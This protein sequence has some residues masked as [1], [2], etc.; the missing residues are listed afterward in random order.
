MINDLL[1]LTEANILLLSEDPLEEIVQLLRNNQYHHL[2]ISNSISSAIKSFEHQIPDLV[3]IQN[4]NQI[5]LSSFSQQLK[6]LDFEQK[7]PPFFLI[8]DKVDETPPPDSIAKDFI[9]TPINQKEFLFRLHHLIKGYLAQV[10]LE[11]YNKTI[12]AAV[13]QRNQALKETQI[14]IIE[15]LGYAAEFRDSE[16]GMH[17]IRVGLYARCM[18][19]AL[20]MSDKESES[21]LFSAPMHDVGKIGIP[22]KILLKP[23]QLTDKEWSIMK[24]HTEIGASI[25]NRSKNNLLQQAGLI[26][27]THHEKWNGSGYPNGLS[28]TDIHLYGRIV[29]IVDVFDALTMERPYKKAWSVEDAVN[30]INEESG[31]HFDP[32]LVDIFNQQLDQFLKIKV[33]HSDDLQSSNLLNDYLKNL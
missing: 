7:I 32:T 6:Q 17:T 29:A 33:M 24:Q 15:C 25:L 5:N 21:L 2:T 19:K 3:I 1:E 28:G 12:L 20:G 14:E 11:S 22:D 31:K 9:S 23:G 16:T 10:E 30:L 8:N 13:K 26:A 18:A 4:N 27:L